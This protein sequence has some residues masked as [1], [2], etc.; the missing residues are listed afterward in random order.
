[1]KRNKED[2]VYQKGINEHQNFIE[3][4]GARLTEL[5]TPDIEWMEEEQGPPKKRLQKSQGPSKKSLQK[6]QRVIEKRQWLNAHVVMADSDADDFWQI[7][8]II[9]L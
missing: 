7:N 3:S 6:S 8:Y 1:M 5:A 4:N 2:N 9:L